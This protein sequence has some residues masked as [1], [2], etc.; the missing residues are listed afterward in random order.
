MSPV[1]HGL[2]P[3]DSVWV[4]WTTLNNSHSSMYLKLL[5][6]YIIKLNLNNFRS[7]FNI[8]TP[9]HVILL[10]QE[11]MDE[12]N[13]DITP[14]YIIFFLIFLT[15]TAFASVIITKF[16]DFLFT[17]SDEAYN[18]DTPAFVFYIHGPVF[19]VNVHHLK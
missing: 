17:P 9:A 2:R 11:E 7:L 15:Y 19:P 10:Y 12:C 4:Y 8:S 18:V 16:K 13:K 5:L 6:H 3:S 14:D 1:A